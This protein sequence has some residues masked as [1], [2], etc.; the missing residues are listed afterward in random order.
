MATVPTYD[1]AQVGPAGLPNAALQGISPR[2]LIQ[3]ELS[4]HEQEAAGE[5]VISAATS[6]IGAAGQANMLANQSRVDT[7]INN[8]LQTGQELTYGTQN[9]PNSGYLAQQGADAL[10]LNDQ[11]QGLAQS[12]GAKLNDAISS[13]AS[14]LGND[15]QRQ[16]FAREA[17]KLSTQFNGLIDSHVLKQ[18][19]ADMLSSWKGTYMQAENAAKTN[20]LDPKALS[21]DPADQ[22]NS[23]LLYQIQRAESAVINSG[24]AQGHAAVQNNADAFNAVSN[25]HAQVVQSALQNNRPDR[26]Q[27]YFD[28]FRSQ[29]TSKDIAD[30]GV[31]ISKEQNAQTATA[32]VQ[33]TAAK[34]APAFSPTNSDRML[35]I[36]SQSESGGNPNAVGPNVPGQG[37]A[38][39][40]M[41]VMDAT[42]ANPGHGIKPEDPNIPGDRDRVG[43]DVLGALMQKYGD[44]AKAWAAYNA[45]EGNVDKALNIAGPG[46]NWLAALGDPVN[47]LQSPANA[48][49]TLDYVNKNVAQLQNGG[50]AAPLS[51]QAD[52]DNDV[53]ARLGPNAQPQVLKLALDESKRQYGEMINQRKV[54][55]ENAVNAAYTYL[56]QNKGDYPSLPAAMLAAV[57]QNAPDKIPS[58]QKYAQDVANPPKADNMAAYHTA[59]SHPDELAKMSD[60]TFQSFAIGNFSE[61]TQKQ[62]SKLRQDAIAGTNDTSAGGLN[63]KALTSELNNRLT[64]LGI[65]TKPKDE[66]GKQRIGTIQKFITDGVFDQQ[67]QMGR[68]MTAQE[69][70]QYIDQQ[71][72]K[73]SQFRNTFLGISGGLQTT[74]YMSMKAGDIPGDQLDQVK[75][76]LAKQGNPNP[77][78]DQ[79]LRTYW[80]WKTK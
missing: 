13:E 69:S 80:A 57:V 73:S 30:S 46:G 1:T 39:G 43:Q 51:S 70:S 52:W 74:P 3:G 62:V 59:I 24:M 16:V 71:F 4:G 33:A 7:A 77:S 34:F 2:A 78:N 10:K 47:K 49:Q 65:D 22:Q 15:A 8:V 18:H 63:S 53:R 20:W 64:S 48:K 28:R 55:G 12:Y 66:E 50:G 58:I 67:Q 40:S 21:D 68:K 54:N 56:A 26:A 61:A 36:T 27:Q 11:G 25:I 41:Q 17:A 32:T 76:S 79:I 37:T 31:Q 38:K 44:P 23:P 29:M 9:A 60:A 6:N 45:G 42:A 5:S 72:L 35:Q 75:T 19:Q 14:N